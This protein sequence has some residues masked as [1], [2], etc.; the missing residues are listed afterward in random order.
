MSQGAQQLSHDLPIFEVIVFASAQP[1]EFLGP[2]LLERWQTDR[3]LKDIIRE[4]LKT[5]D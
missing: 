1:E 3:T 2:H 5:V 4:V